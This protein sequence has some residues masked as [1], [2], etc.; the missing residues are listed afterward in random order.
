M[1]SSLIAEP[2]AT[3]PLGRQRVYRAV[4]AEIVRQLGQHPEEWTQ[5][6]SPGYA[7]EPVF[8]PLQFSGFPFSGINRS[9]LY[10][11]GRLRGFESPLWFP[12]KKI[13]SIGGRIRSGEKGTTVFQIPLVGSVIDSLSRWRH[14]ERTSFLPRCRVFNVCQCEGL[15]KWCSAATDIWKPMLKPPVRLM[16]LVRRAGAVIRDGRWPCYRGQTDEIFMPPIARFRNA[17]S[18]ARGVCH[19]L[20]H[21]ANH[22]SRLNHDFGAVEYADEGWAMEEIV[23]ELGAAF[24]CAVLRITRQVSRSHAAYIHSW[25]KPFH[26]DVAVVQTAAAIAEKHVEFLHGIGS[27]GAE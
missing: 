11:V 4:T 23:A 26:G 13:V 3:L 22:T 18:Y 6:W 1:N 15:P 12:E 9:I 2:P 5:S 25:L 14:G 21:W 7:G 17:Q 8:P 16:A 24:L 10:A 27:S 20:M 19:E